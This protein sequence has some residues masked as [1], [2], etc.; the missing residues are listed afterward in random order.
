MRFEFFC[1]FPFMVGVIDSIRQW[2]RLTMSVI[3]HFSFGLLFFFVAFTFQLLSTWSHARLVQLKRE[4][5]IFVNCCVVFLNIC[6]SLNLICFFL[7]V[8]RLQKRLLLLKVICVLC[9]YFLLY[10][11]F[12][13]SLRLTASL[14]FPLSSRREHKSANGNFVLPLFD[15]SYSNN[16]PSIVSVYF[17]SFIRVSTLARNISKYASK[18]EQVAIAFEH[19]RKLPLIGKLFS[20]LG[21]VQFFSYVRL[22]LSFVLAT[23]NYIFTSCALRSVYKSAWSYLSENNINVHKVEPM[24]TECLITS[25]KCIASSGES[26]VITH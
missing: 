11:K 9:V 22:F 12:M 1:F 15:T 13:I 21:E 19:K 17:T 24:L 23:L 26:K 6:V 14:L 3:S 16:L 10:N 8:C 2:L 25:L 5:C 7:A 20:C 18:C 4:S